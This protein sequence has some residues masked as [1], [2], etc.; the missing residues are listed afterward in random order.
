MSKVFLET[1]RMKLRGWQPDDVYEFARIN[2]D[3]IVM[4]FYPARLDGAATTRL[5]EHFDGHIEKKGY[6]FFAVE[7]KKSGAFMGF[8]GLADAPK[9]MPFAPATELAW[10]LDYGYWGNGFATEATQA[11]LDHG[12]ETLAL[13]EIVAYCVVD[14]DRAHGVLNKLGFEQAKSESFRYA[15]QRSKASV[16]DYSLF[17]MRSA[18]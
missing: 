3:P 13:P 15:P 4:E 10:R 17:R 5:V 16:A 18:V 9:R 12:F 8:A 11:L 14:H 1:E 2:N 7:E 6:G